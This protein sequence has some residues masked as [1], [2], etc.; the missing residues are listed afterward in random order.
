MWTDLLDCFP[1]E[2]GLTRS[3]VSISARL[4]S[5]Q[6]AILYHAETL[7][8]RLASC[9]S[10]CCPLQNVWLSRSKHDGLVLSGRL[11]VRHKIACIY[12]QTAVRLIS[13]IS[14]THY[15][16]QRILL[17]WP[18]LPASTFSLIAYL[19]GGIAMFQQVLGA[20]RLPNR[21]MCTMAEEATCLR[22]SGLN[23]VTVSGWLYI[24][25]VTLDMVVMISFDIACLADE[26][27]FTAYV[28][29]HCC[30]PALPC[31]RMLRMLKGII[32]MLSCR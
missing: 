7:R 5:T 19:A 8:R 22:T 17:A 25:S 15:S 3:P 10:P 29:Y 21:V 28:S 16:V 2:P 32:I 9:N 23:S 26:V 27:C 18:C 30:S 13:D 12:T 6:E 11:L 31:W 4:S 1:R 14:T 20:S 24:S